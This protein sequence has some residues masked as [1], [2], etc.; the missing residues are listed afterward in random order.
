MSNTDP[1]NTPAA[2]QPTTQSPASAP[3]PTF[4][5]AIVQQIAETAFVTLQRSADP[6]DIGLE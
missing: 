2:V 1:A 3:A 4:D 5:P 6:A